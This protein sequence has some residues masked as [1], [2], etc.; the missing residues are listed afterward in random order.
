MLLFSFINK[1]HIN[2][3]EDTGKFIIDNT[4]AFIEIWNLADVSS[5][6]K[7]SSM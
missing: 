6:S 1:I 7:Q 2:G 4:V 5:K 3:K